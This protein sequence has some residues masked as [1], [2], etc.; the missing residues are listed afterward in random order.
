M[1]N[2]YVSACGRFLTRESSGASVWTLLGKKGEIT[3]LAINSRSTVIPVLCGNTDVPKPFFLK[4]YWRQRKI[5]SVQGLK[6]EVGVFE[7]VMEQ[8]GRKTADVFDYD[9]MS[10]DTLPVQKK[11]S[12]PLNVFLRVPQLTDLD[13]MAPLQA[14]YEQEEVLPKGS[15][16]SALASRTNLANIIAQ[17]QILAAEVKGRLVGKINISAVSYT[18]YQVG[19]VY[20]HPDF[21]RLGIARLMAQEFIAPL[22]KQGRGVTLFVKKNNLAARKLYSGLGFSTRNN[23]RITYY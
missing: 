3:A 23:Y 16:F 21:R 11:Y 1:E 8:I 12:G 4:G 17:K 6:E 5:H 22:I 20:V 9:L 18:R 14:A 10:L 2:N 7:K 19:G 13:A 15:V